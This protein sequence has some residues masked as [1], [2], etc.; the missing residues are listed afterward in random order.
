MKEGM[1]MEE[2]KRERDG[3]RQI[4]NMTAGDLPN[5]CINK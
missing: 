3:E 4:E 2:G 1:G 5:V